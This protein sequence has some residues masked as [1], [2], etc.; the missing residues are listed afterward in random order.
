MHD[1]R[2]NV[3]CRTI[4]TDSVSRDCEEAKRYRIRWKPKRLDGWRA[5]KDFLILFL[6]KTWKTKYSAKAVDTHTSNLDETINKQKLVQMDQRQSV[7]QCTT[8]FR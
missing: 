7:I 8:I 2:D 6:L 4:L 1:V 3:T 5:G